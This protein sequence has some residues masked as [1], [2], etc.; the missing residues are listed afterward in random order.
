MSFGQSFLPEP[1]CSYLNAQE[2]SVDVAGLHH[3]C[4]PWPQSPDE[5]TS[6]DVWRLKD[7]GV[8]HVDVLSLPDASIR[9]LG[10]VGPHRALQGGHLNPASLH[11]DT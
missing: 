3:F 9:A 8:L 7:K 4:E 1:L 11:C 5:H 2:S 6:C 10:A